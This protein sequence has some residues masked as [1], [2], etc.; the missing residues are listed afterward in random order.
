M[1]HGGLGE[2][3]KSGIELQTHT[4]LCAS[5]RR[6]PAASDRVTERLR[7][8]SHPLRLLAL[9]IRVHDRSQQTSPFGR[10]CFGASSRSTAI[11]ID[12]SIE[13]MTVNGIPPS[14]H[15]QRGGEASGGKETL[16]ELQ[17]G[18]DHLQPPRQG[19]REA[20]G[21]FAGI[22]R[23]RRWNA[24]WRSPSRR[25]ATRGSRTS[26]RC[27]STAS[28]RAPAGARSGQGHGQQGRPRGAVRLRTE[29]PAA[30][31]AAALLDH[32]AKGDVHVRSAGS[33]PG[34]HQP[35]RDHGDGGA[36]HRSFEGVPE[37]DDRRGRAG[38]RCGGHDGLW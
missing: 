38:S 34:P 30:A 12:I 28:P 8:P 36:R 15:L 32:Y 25:S 10:F 7:H 2:A 35:E 27:S 37:A 11:Y 26:C 3:S 33:A 13:I 17:V 18:R 5:S 14:D 24:S 1:R 4:F 29:R 20:R 23:A 22:S 9:D 31:M 21:E 16:S 6:R 19:A